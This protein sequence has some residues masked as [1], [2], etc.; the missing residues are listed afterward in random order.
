M[1]ATSTVGSVSGRSAAQGR[2]RSPARAFVMRPLP[3]H[4][5]R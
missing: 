1:T 4:K 2:H 3:V 5:S